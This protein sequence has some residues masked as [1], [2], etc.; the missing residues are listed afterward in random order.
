MVL[1]FSEVIPSNKYSLLI[2]F[3]YCCQNHC[4]HIFTAIFS[5]GMNLL[6]FF[7]VCVFSMLIMNSHI[8]F[9]SAAPEYET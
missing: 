3:G 6:S 5:Q 2:M 8:H 4:V 1:Q 7:Q 9:Y